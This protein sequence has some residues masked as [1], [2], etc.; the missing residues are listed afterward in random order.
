VSPFHLAI[1]QFSLSEKET[2]FQQLGR[3]FENRC[4]EL[5]AI[6]VD[7]RLDCVRSSGEF[8]SLVSRLQ[9]PVPPRPVA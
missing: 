2:G 9:L 5:T 4:F 6:K 8:D 1:L 3:A 7:P